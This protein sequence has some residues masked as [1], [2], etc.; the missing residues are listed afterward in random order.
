MGDYK[1]IINEELNDFLNENDYKLILDVAKNTE[2]AEYYGSMFGQDVEPKGT[3]V[4]QGKAVLDGWV[5]GKAYLKNPLF[6]D[7]DD[8]NLIQYKR[9]LAT[10]YK[11]T[12]EKLTKKLMD[13]GYDSIVTK[14][15]DGE[16]NE[17]V[18]F[19]N[20]NFNLGF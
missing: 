9:D 3:Y 20:A 4:I 6:I 8:N 10:K 19:P 2:P 5:D 14:F 7:V 11:A 17:I 13:L 18:L 16:Y 1:K 15:P 12:G